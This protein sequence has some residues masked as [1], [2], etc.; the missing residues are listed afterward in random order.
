MKKEVRQNEK[1][2]KL[3][4]ADDSYFEILFLEKKH[5]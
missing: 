2:I 1:K 5:G 4:E 3:Q